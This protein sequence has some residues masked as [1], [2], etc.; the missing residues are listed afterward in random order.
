M[1][2]LVIKM[3]HQQVINAYRNEIHRL[4]AKVAEEHAVARLSYFPVFNHTGLG[5]W[6]RAGS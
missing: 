2:L 1:S 3:I 4:S 6:P 5:K